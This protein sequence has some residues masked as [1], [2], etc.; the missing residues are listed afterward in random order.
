MGTPRERKSIKA[1]NHGS[2][3]SEPLGASTRATENTRVPSVRERARTAVC[4]RASGSHDNHPDA[5]REVAHSGSGSDARPAFVEPRPGPGAVGDHAAAIVAQLEELRG[6]I[7]TLRS[8]G[9]ARRYR[10]TASLRPPD[11]ARPRAP[12]VH[13]DPGV[14]ALGGFMTC[15]AVPTPT[16]NFESPLMWQLQEELYPPGFWPPKLSKYRGGLR[17][18]GVREEL[19]PGHRC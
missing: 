17:P 14:G 4:E 12:A 10:R 7:V 16:V 2:Q 6:A 19:C 15:S 18:C 5:K 1:R 8:D 9:A 11:A 13:R 3:D